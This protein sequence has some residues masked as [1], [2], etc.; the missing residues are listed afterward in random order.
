[1]GLTCTWC[2]LR[3]FCCHRRVKR[4]HRQK[5]NVESRIKTTHSYTQKSIMISR[6]RTMTSLLLSYD[7]QL[8]LFLWLYESIQSFSNP[9]SESSSSLVN[10]KFFS[11]EESA[12]KENR[13]ICSDSIILLACDWGLE[14]R[15]LR[16]VL[17]SWFSKLLLFSL[18][19]YDKPLISAFCVDSRY[20]SEPDRSHIYPKSYNILNRTWPLGRR[21]RGSYS[22]RG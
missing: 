6:S 12:W 3:I 2:W 10:T 7:L 19:H 5:K 20:R 11:E 8:L 17:L 21:V 13:L 16:R 4:S 9:T 14:S 22:T 15:E 1:M 18:L